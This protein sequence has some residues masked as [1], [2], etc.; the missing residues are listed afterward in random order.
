MVQNVLLSDS[1]LF[2][3]L[4]KNRLG[5]AIPQRTRAEVDHTSLLLV[6]QAANY[7]SPCERSS[8][9]ICYLLN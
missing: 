8:T 3:A 6:S 5:I 4:H 1:F 9:R 2:K 7:L